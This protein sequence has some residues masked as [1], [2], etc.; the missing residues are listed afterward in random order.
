MSKR[1]KSLVAGIAFAV[2]LFLAV[3]GIVTFMPSVFAD[4]HSHSS[5]TGY[6]GLDDDGLPIVDRHGVMLVF[7]GEIASE[8]VSVDT[9]E[10]SLNDGSFA[11]I[12]ETRVKGAHVFLK[13][14]DELA[15]DARPIVG[16]AEGEEVEDLAGNSTNRQKLGFVQIKDGIAPRLTVTLSGGS[17][18]GTGSE[19]PNRLTKD[20]ID[21][22]ITS[23]E[24]LQG[25][26]RVVVVC[27][28]LNWTESVGGR[29]VE[30]DV[31]DFIANRNGA[32]PSKPQEPRGT[33]Y[34]CGYDADGDGMDDPFKLT[35]DIADSRPGEVWEYTWRNP[36]GSTTGLRDGELV[37]VAY[38]RDRSRYDR[39]GEDV[40]NWAVATDGFGLDT[41]FEG[42]IVPNGVRVHPADGAKT[43]E[44][45]PFVLI[46]FL[47]TNSV[48]LNSMLFD[49]VEVF[50]EIQDLGDNRF[51][52]W[53]LSMNRGQ[54][55][56]DVGARDSA[57]NNFEFDFSFESVERGDF[58]LE[59]RSGW[60]AVSIPVAPIYTE[61][62]A[63]FSEKAVQVVVGWNKG[64]WSIAM[65][66]EGAW[67]HNTFFEPLARITEGYGYW[68]KTSEFVHQRVALVGAYCVPGK[69]CRGGVGS[70]P[71]FPGWNF[72]GVL[73]RDI[74]QTED[75][76]GDAL[77]D[78]NLE[79][80]FAQEYLGEY[81]VAFTWEATRDRFEPLLRHDPMMIGDGV[82]VYYDSSIEPRSF[83]PLAD[84]PQ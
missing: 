71:A 32:F 48:K 39:Y 17:G 34:T 68:V 1:N 29:D 47:E 78:Y 12:V 51:L 60:N 38:G 52:Y 46:E 64:R 42:A 70:P 26:P 53:P 15:S 66:R 43:S 58:V 76:F 25:A 30:R 28:G 82:W 31:D 40:S 33:D 19:G 37:V 69:G 8:T 24:P 6:F 10:V 20:A 21:V 80:I 13:L 50:D 55:T 56:V 16:I 59:L 22:R 81:K 27:E 41:K 18:I 4:N 67:Q 49:G 2:F 62:S 84:R 74:D 72:V 11:E 45:R 75:H 35:E 23:D 54:H 14:E 65:R 3:I 44:A 9:F 7:D 57:G 63:V 5:V 73:D 36:A 79:P 61:I 77:R 83:T